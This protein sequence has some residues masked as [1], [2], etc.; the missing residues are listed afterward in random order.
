MRLFN[1]QR[2]AQNSQTVEATYKNHLDDRV[3]EGVFGAKVSGKDASGGTMRQFL[4]L[5]AMAIVGFF[6]MPN[7]TATASMID[8]TSMT[9]AQ[10]TMQSHTANAVDDVIDILEEILDIL[11]DKKDKDGD[12]DSGISGN[13]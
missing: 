3:L 7:T 5:I 6:A 4:A 2:T 9:A 10:I 13:G 11:E 12:D 1:H 8:L